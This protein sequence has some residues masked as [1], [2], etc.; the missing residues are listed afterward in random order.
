MRRYPVNLDI[1]HQL[2]VIVG[3]GTV[4]KRKV[5]GLLP[6]GARVVVISPELCTGLQTF[7]DQ[8]KIEWKQRG[9]RTGDLEGA[10]LVFAA[11]NSDPIQKMVKDEA[12]TAGLLVNVV[13]DP[14]SC[15]FQVPALFRQGALLITIGTDGASPALAARIRNELALRYGA[16]YAILLDLMAAVRK[17]VVSG[18]GNQQEHKQLFEKL[19]NSD[20]LSLVA[21]SNWERLRERLEELLP[22]EMEVAA[23]VKSLQSG[24]DGS[25][26]TLSC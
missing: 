20:I 21:A 25:M 3:G 9:Y 10:K 26:E 8:G 14:E 6:C 4:A 16:E 22:P 1:H 24:K 5:E 17:H 19:L 12:D 15:S 23:L 13:T 2:C 7:A 11:T 18:C